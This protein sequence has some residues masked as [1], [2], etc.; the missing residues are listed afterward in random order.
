MM[1]LV[2]ASALTILVAAPAL[3]QSSNREPLRNVARPNFSTDH[4]GA[5]NQSLAGGSVGRE[6]AIRDCNDQGRRYTASGAAAPPCCARRNLQDATRFIEIGS[7]IWS[8]I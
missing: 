7:H 6:Q 2:A 3:A 8:N 5:Y 1:R 4:F